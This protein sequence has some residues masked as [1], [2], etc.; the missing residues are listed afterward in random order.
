[1]FGEF[2]SPAEVGPLVA[3]PNS[4]SPE[5]QD[6]PLLMQW[7]TLYSAS[8]KAVS[9]PVPGGGGSAIGDVDGLVLGDAVGVFEGVFEGGGEVGLVVGDFE[10]LVLG[11]AVIGLTDGDPLG[12]FEGDCEGLDVGVAVGDSVVG[13]MTGLLEGESV[14]GALVGAREGDRLGLD[15]GCE[16]NDVIERVEE[17]VIEFINEK[18]RSKKQGIL[19]GIQIC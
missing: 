16:M 18:T 6:V 13:V 9:A 17:H 2:N 5:E 4:R 10:G 12:L 11:D 19:L 14:I 7:G 15:V 3:L 1:V 8:G